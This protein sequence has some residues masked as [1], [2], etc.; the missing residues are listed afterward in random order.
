MQHPWL[1]GFFL[2]L[3]LVMAQ[4]LDAP[5]DLLEA[6]KEAALMLGG[7]ETAAGPLLT[8]LAVVAGALIASLPARLRNRGQRREPLRARRCAVCFAGGLMSALGLSLA[9]GDLL[10][11]AFLG[12]FNGVLGGLVFAGIAALSGGLAA[13]VAERRRS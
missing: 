9:G 8:A 12:S 4:V 11:L 2:A 7:R 3:A 13:T 1:C 5:I 10:T 6:A